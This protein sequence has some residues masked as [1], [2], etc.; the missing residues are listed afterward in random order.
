M[1]Y[2]SGENMITVQVLLLVVAAQALNLG[3][4][5]TQT[6]YNAT[7]YLSDLDARQTKFKTDINSIKSQIDQINKALNSSILTPS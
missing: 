3:H 2:K 6:Y 7:N 4:K 5:Q 1:K